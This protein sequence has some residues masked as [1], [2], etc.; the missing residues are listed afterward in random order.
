L[1]LP[2]GIHPQLAELA[3]RAAL[4]Q[5]SQDHAFAKRRRH[6]GHPKIDLG[7]GRR[8][9]QVPV[10]RDEPLGDIEL[11]HDLDTANDRS[12]EVLGRGRHLVQDAVN[13]VLDPKLVLERLDMDIAGAVVDRF[14]DD[15]VHQIDQRGLADQILQI[16]HGV[17]RFR[18]VDGVDLVGQRVGHPCSGRPVV[19]PEGVSQNPW[20]NVLAGNI[21]TANRRQII[22]RTEVE[23]ILHRQFKSAIIDT[24]RQGA[25]AMGQVRRQMRQDLVR[26][27]DL[28]QL[29]AGNSELNRQRVPDVILFHHAEPT[30]MLAE[31]RPVAIG[32]TGRPR[33]TVRRQ[34]AQLNKNLA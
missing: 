25:I 21:Q 8:E 11:G 22:N 5:N 2:V 23:R 20:P 26:D 6:G 3:Q 15:Q 28:F 31:P 9:F 32:G 4:I 30:Q 29:D 7:I 14:E 19:P 18:H 33:E 27:V 12:L 13:P 10:L 24:Q 34:I 16:P 17:N 1:P